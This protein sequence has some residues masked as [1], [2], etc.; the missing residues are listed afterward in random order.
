MSD[1]LKNEDTLVSDLASSNV[2]NLTGILNPAD[3][4]NSEINN[5]GS[6]NSLLSGGY[7]TTS[8][9]AEDNTVTSELGT[10]ECGGVKYTGQNSDNIEIN[11]D[12]NVNSISATLKRIKFDSTADFPEVGSERLI[13]I[14]SSNKALYGWDSKKGVYYKLVADVKVPTNLSEFNNDAGFIDKS[15]NDLENYYTKSQ[16]DS[17]VSN[18]QV[19]LSDYYTK[20]ETYSQEQIN[21]LLSTSS[22][23][24]KI[25]WRK[26]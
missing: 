13:Y 6:I 25:I 11:V 24:T 2:D 1:C 17:I 16:V 21:D 14:D 10:G 7:E 15:V 22:G 12:N 18:V 23:G 9:V 26:W 19:D 4:V 20:D 8:T 3:V 5:G